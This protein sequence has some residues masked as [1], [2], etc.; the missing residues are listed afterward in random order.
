MDPDPRRQRIC[1]TMDSIP[2][3]R[4]A[5]YGQVAEEAGL[6]RR[7]RLVGSILGSLTAGSRLPWHRVVNAK[8]EIAARRGSGPREQARRLRREGV[9]VDPRGRVCLARYGWD[10]GC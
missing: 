8:G 5:T 3:G 10:G 1:A 6:P 4:V 2:A 7:A 9:S